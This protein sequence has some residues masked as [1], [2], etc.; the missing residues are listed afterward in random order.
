MD[1]NYDQ[2]A[3]LQPYR[4]NAAKAFGAIYGYA[5]LS[6]PLSEPVDVV[7][8]S[9]SQIRDCGHCRDMHTRDRN[10]KGVKVEKPAT[11]LAWEEGGFF[12]AAECAALAYAESVTRVG[13][14]GAPE[15]ACR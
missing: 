11:A 12:S 3:R 6:G 2:E 15:S 9:V 8:M 4:F 13:E 10:R 14:T 7:H 1:Q 5:M